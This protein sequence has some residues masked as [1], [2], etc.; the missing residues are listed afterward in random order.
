M[1]SLSFIYTFVF[2]ILSRFLNMF[3]TLNVV[4]EKLLKNAKFVI[5]TILKII[6]QQLF[7]FYSINLPGESCC[8][9]LNG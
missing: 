8:D 6:L 9:Q 7:T 1:H 2:L 4:R 5:T 3:T